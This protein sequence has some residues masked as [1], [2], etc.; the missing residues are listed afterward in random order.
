MTSSS[1]RGLFAQRVIQVR[2]PAATAQAG[3]GMIEILVAVLVLSIGCLGIAA[4]QA[5]A[6]STNNSSLARSMATVASY[7]ILDAMR[8]DLVNA[9]GNSYN[10]TVKANACPAAGASLAS[11]QINQWCGQLGANL[12]ATA[13][14]IGTIACTAAAGTTTTNCTITIQFDDSR[15][16]DGG[17]TTQ[18]VITQALL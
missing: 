14:T 6:L 17:S 18:S 9:V 4:L 7:S 12:G 10:T 5:R 11:A 15:A 3:V 8:A 2:R 1:R 16:G 13:N